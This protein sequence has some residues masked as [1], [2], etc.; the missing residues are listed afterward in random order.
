MK[1]YGRAPARLVVSGAFVLGLFSIAGAGATYAEPVVNEV[2]LV[3]AKTDKCA[4][5]AGGLSTLNSHPAV[6]FRCDSDPSRRWRL[7]E[8]SRGIYQIRNVQTGKCLTIKGGTS[9]ANNLEAVQFNCDS[10]PSRRWRINDVTGNGFHQLRNVK[11]GKCL[12]ILGGTL[13]DD[14]LPL[15]QFDCD[16]DLSRQWTIRLKL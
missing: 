14:N 10:D 9:S 13:P 2:M 4:T 12:T 7:N 1:I 8:T 6:Q 11:T 15:L 5:I 16:S 3:N